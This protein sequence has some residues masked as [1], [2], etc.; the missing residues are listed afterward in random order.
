[1]SDS[2]GALIGAGS[3]YITDP[4]QLPITVIAEAKLYIKT[5]QTARSTCSDVNAATF[6]GNLAYRGAQASVSVADTYVTC[7]TLSGRGRL[8]LVI[9]PSYAGGAFTPTARITIDGTVYTIAPSTTI[10][11][12]NRLVIGATTPGTPTIASGGTYDTTD[13]ALPNSYNDGGFISAMVGGFYNTTSNIGIV[14][15]EVIE[16]YNMPFI[17]FDSSCVVEFKTSLLAAG[18]GDKIG[19]AVY[20]MLP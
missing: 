16:A 7:A 20:R 19:G 9:P 8:Y 2:S 17:Q 4:R 1:M 6:F 14:T 15:P 3:R 13:F 11:A 18:T 12:S 10:S 5:N